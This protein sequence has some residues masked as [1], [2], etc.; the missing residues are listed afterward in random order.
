MSQDKA[1]CPGF[2]LDYRSHSCYRLQRNTVDEALEPREGFNYF[3]K[4]CLRGQL[5]GPVGA[6]L[7]SQAVT[8]VLL[9]PSLQG[10][11]NI[12]GIRIM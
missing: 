1:T 11:I 10:I 12:S 8:S 7:V 2:A 6:V 9:L 5:V 4:I 3:Q